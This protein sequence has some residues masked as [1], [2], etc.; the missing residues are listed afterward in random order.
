MAKKNKRYKKINLSDLAHSVKAN[1][2]VEISNEE[3]AAIKEAMV[4]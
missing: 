1:V 3:Q 2:K 4:S